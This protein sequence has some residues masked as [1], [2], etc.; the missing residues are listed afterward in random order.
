[1]GRRSIQPGFSRKLRPGARRGSVYVLALMISLVVT[2]MGVGAALA[3]QSELAAAQMRVQS[4]QTRIAAQ[5]AL[6]LGLA[7]AQNTAAWR[8]SA[9]A[10]T[11][12]FVSTTLGG[13]SMVVQVDD[14]AGAAPSSDTTKP[15]R[16]RATASIG[17]ARHG[18]QGTFMPGFVPPASLSAVAYAGGNISFLSTATLKS[19]DTIGSNGSVTAVA[20]T[21]QPA[22]Y[23]A[24]AI[25]GLTFSGGTSSGRARLALPDSSLV[26]KYVARGTA[27]AYASVSPRLQ[28]CLLAPVSNPFGAVNASGIYVINCAGAPITVSDLR[29]YGTLVLLDPGAGSLIEKSVAFEPVNAGEPCLVVRGSIELSTDASDLAES[30]LTGNFNPPGA[31]YLGVT[32]TNNTGSFASVLHGI[33]YATGNIVITKNV[34]MEGVLVA[35]G[36]VTFGVAAATSMRRVLGGT[37]AS[38]FQVFDRWDLDSSTFERV[39]Y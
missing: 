12:G 17:A 10:A 35:G 11:P 18:L 25:T 13:V 6:E 39:T 20:A 22:V 8:S 30:N 5:S 7:R 24:G 3:A 28:R 26:D 14:G 37:V 16:F 34:T 31:P 38:E 4:V 27:I 36:D 23:A 33:V 19:S 29:V 32:D 15:V 21:V 2:A 9:N 1:M